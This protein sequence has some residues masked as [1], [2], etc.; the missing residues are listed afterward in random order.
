[1]SG[2][3]NEQSGGRSG[4][5]RGRGGSRG[6]GGRGGRGRGRGRGGGGRGGGNSNKKQS[7]ASSSSAGEQRG[8][9]D[10][11]AAAALS[12]ADLESI[13]MHR[14]NP[15]GHPGGGSELSAGAS[16]FVP[17]GASASAPAH[18]QDGT[19]GGNKGGMKNS[20]RGNKSK[21]KGGSKGAADEAKEVSGESTNNGDKAG[22]QK[23]KKKKGGNKGSDNK[24]EKQNQ[25]DSTKKDK[26]KDAGNQSGNKKKDDKQ[27]KKKG[28]KSA[29]SSKPTNAP[30][31]P[32]IPP[33][34]P[35]TTNPLSYGKGNKISV[36][37]IAEKPSIAQAIAKGLSSI[38]GSSQCNF[39]GGGRSLPTHDIPHLHFPKAPN[40]ER[41]SHKVTSVAGHVFGTDFGSEYQSWDSV[42][43]AE[44]FH[45]PIVKKTQK[46]SVVKHLQ[47][48]ARGCDFVV[49]WLDCDREGENI[50]FEVLDC[51]MHLMKSGGDS[52]VANYDRVYRAYFSA[53][54]PSDISKAY[55]LL[56]KPDKCQSLSVDA[57]QELDLKVGV[58]FSRFQ[59]RY[60]QGRYGDL[61]SAVLSY[62]P[63]QTPTLG[64]CVQRHIEIE[65]FK[66]TP[67]W[68]L[69]LGVLKRGRMCRAQ[70]ASGRSFNQNKTNALVQLCKDTPGA[71]A[72]V[73]SVVTKE[74]KQG[75]PTPLNTV[76]MLKAASKALGMGPHAAMQCAERLYLVSK[77]LQT[78]FRACR[79]MPTD[80]SPLFPSPS[81]YFHF[82]ERIPFLS[83]N[84]INCLPNLFRCQGMPS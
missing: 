75:R 81:F 38:Q 29:T 68:V 22:D 64:F 34:Q 16:E 78:L 23:S 67:Y 12:S 3:N 19:N 52:G 36:I 42:D 7:N 76:Q 60:F 4:G 61:D 33:S 20:R 84:R 2:S 51:I 79:R 1:M 53:I 21:N 26:K 17:P 14:L 15:S 18:Q 55:G 37:H 24:K 8:A 56:G 6:R 72:E 9:D 77:R 39:G 65:T 28:G 45:A 73:L 69:D 30:L 32:A 48:E 50:A 44:L 54:N 80:S 71:S 83:Q 5:G 70:W 47:T 82:S 40:A 43:P 59:T 41:C 31:Q 46:G 35:Q 62:G 13:G 58:A 57:R 25:Q 10:S 74:K 27:S 11:A 66:P 63:C 49:L